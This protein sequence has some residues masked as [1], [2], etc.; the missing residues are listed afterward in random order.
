MSGVRLGGEAF[1]YWLALELYRSYLRE[2]ER[3][4]LIR[5][6]RPRPPLPQAARGPSTGFFRHLLRG[7]ETS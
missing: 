6:I 5:E 1:S 7:R 2:A 3:E 4:R